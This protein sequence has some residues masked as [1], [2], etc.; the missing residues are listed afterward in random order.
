MTNHKETWESRAV[1]TTRGNQTFLGCIINRMIGC[2]TGAPAFCSMTA[3]H[4]T[5]DGHLIADFRIAPDRP[6]LA[7]RVG[8][9]FEIHHSLLKLAD[10]LK[11]NNA[12]R[13]AMLEAMRQWIGSDDR[14][15]A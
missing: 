12:D 15:T 10:K 14:V 6:F 13:E 11:L 7:T 3:A 2:E 9:L 5:R 1:A 8:F 4:I